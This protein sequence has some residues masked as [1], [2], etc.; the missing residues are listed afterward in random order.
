MTT[1]AG[2]SGRRTNRRGVA[3]RQ[4]MLDAALRS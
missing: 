4:A 2:V 3:T 1:R